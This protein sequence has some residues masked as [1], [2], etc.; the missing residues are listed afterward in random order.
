MSEAENSALLMMCDSPS[1]RA[2]PLPRSWEGAWLQASPYGRR[3]TKGLRQM[4]KGGRAL[5]MLTIGAAKERTVR[6][7]FHFGCSLVYLFWLTK[8]F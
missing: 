8:Q 7:I 3:G 2:V 6:M 4:E 1:D 5:V